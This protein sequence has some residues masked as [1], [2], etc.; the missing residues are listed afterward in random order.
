MAYDR[1]SKD[2]E[3]IK[4]RG[5]NVIKTGDKV[6]S[7]QLAAW[8]RVITAQSQEPFFAKV[9]QSQKAWVKRTGAYLLVNNLDTAAL[10]ESLQALRL[11][12][13]LKLRSARAASSP[14]GLPPRVRL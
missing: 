2:L 13:E 11:G 5:V 7:D 14:R 9:I 6:L 3:A 10:R 12:L 1:Y 4:A 8:D